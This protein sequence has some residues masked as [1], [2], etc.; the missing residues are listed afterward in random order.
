M[1]FT[2]LSNTLQP[3]TLLMIP[4]SSMSRNPSKNLEMFFIKVTSVVSAKPSGGAKKAA[5]AS[6]RSDP[7]AADKEMCRSLI[8]LCES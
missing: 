6:S 4:T 2:V 8:V 7:H 5:V 3:T 1:T